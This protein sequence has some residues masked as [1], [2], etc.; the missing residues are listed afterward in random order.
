MT[1]SPPARRHGRCAKPR[2]RP[3]RRC[4]EPSDLP[5]LRR[6]AHPQPGRSRPA[7]PRQC[8]G[9]PGHAGA[10]SRLPAPR[11]RLRPMPARP[12]RAGGAAP[13]AVRGGLSL[14]LLFLRELAR[15]LRRARGRTDRSPRPPAGFERGRDR[16]QRRRLAL[17]LPGARR[18]GLGVEPSAGVAEAA[19]ARGLRTEIAFFGEA[20]ARR[21]AGEGR[22]DLI[23]AT[24]VLAHVPDIND[25]LAGVRTLLAPEGLFAVEFPHLLNLIRE[26]QFD[27]IYHEH[28]TYLSLLALRTALERNGLALVDA[29][30]QPTHGGSLRVL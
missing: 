12:G 28:F 1:L 9:R 3:G 30:R 29:E 6:R 13:R 7:A 14:F 21:L 5:G 19:R 26:T 16:Q 27:T 23:V 15:P 11:P 24:N 2:S 22:A 4:R 17:L 8:P 20:A 18:A 25:F 10:R